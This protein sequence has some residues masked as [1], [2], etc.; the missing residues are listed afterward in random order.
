MRGSPSC[1]GSV[2]VAAPPPSAP[3]SANSPMAHHLRRFEILLPL[4]FND[5]RKVPA[6]LLEL[7]LAELK[8]QFGGLSS[9]SQFTRGFDRNTS[10]DEFMVRLFA[11]VADTA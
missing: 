3:R 7:T 8:I 9:D 6:E 4:T 10:G 5:G 11:D 2:A 1:R